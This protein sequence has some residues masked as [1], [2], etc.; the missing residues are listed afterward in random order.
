MFPSQILA[1]VQ[2]RFPRYLVSFFEDM[3]ADIGW[4]KPQNRRGKYKLSKFL[5]T[6]GI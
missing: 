6:F 1:N 5:P 2:K 4:K 3:F